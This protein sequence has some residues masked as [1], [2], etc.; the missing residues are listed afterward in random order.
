MR[1]L[2]PRRQEAR[3]EG[4]AE[5][6]S[7]DATGAGAEDALISPA[8]LTTETKTPP[9]LRGPSG[10]WGIFRKLQRG[11]WAPA[12]VQPPA[13]PQVLLTSGSC[14]APPLQRPRDGSCESCHPRLLALVPQLTLRSGV[15]PRQA[16]WS[17][18]DGAKDRKV[19][20]PAGVWARAWPR[21]TQRGSS[22]MPWWGTAKTRGRGGGAEG[23]VGAGGLDTNSAPARVHELRPVA[24][25]RE[26]VN[27]PV[28]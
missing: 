27:R 25:H 8:S 9:P 7:Q 13:K 2:G 20:G 26:N 23:K 18:K 3:R 19:E 28:G 17:W 16:S 6:E 21:D 12:A 5:A 14:L 15:S 22:N 24:T 10:N 1:P 11:S 4:A